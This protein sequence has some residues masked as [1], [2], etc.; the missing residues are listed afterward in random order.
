[1]E[2]KFLFFPN[3]ECANIPNLTRGVS[4]CREKLKPRSDKQIIVYRALKKQ[5]ITSDEFIPQL[6]MQQVKPYVLTKACNF[7]GL[8]VFLS[9][10]AFAVFVATPRIANV[11]SFSAVGKIIETVHGPIEEKPNPPHVTWHPYIDINPKNLFELN[12]GEE[13]QP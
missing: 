7:C 10:E 3:K 1:M 13:I 8:S 5:N 2:T 11:F 9:K 4:C 6:A 12:S